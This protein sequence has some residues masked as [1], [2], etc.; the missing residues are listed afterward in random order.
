KQD[1]LKPQG[2]PEHPCVYVTP[3]DVERVRRNARDTAWG[4]TAAAALL[5]SCEPW[6]QHDDAYWRAFL[7]GPGACYAYGFVACPTCGS[8]WGTWGGARCDWDTPGKVTCANGHQ[9]PDAAHPDS[10]GGWHNPDGRIH[11]FV[12]SWNAWVTE[13]WTSAIPTLADAYALTADEKY[14]DRAALFLDL[15]ASIYPETQAGSWDYPSSPPSGRFARPW[16]QV[17][18]TLV[19]YVHAQDL[20]Y[21]SSAL[22]RPSLRPAIAAAFPPQPWPQQA[23]V[24][25]T[26]RR[27]TSHPGMTRRENIDLNL[28]EDGAYY[29][30]GHCFGGMLHNGHADYMRGSLA[31]GALLGI[32]EYIRIATD[33]PYSFWAMVANNCDRDGRY[34]ETSLGYAIHARNL[35]LTFVEPLRNWRNV[36]HPQGYDL[37]ADARFRSFYRLPATVLDCAG[38]EPNF[39]DSSPDHACYTSSARPYRREDHEFAEWLYAGT[40][41]AVKD[42][43]ASVL[44]WMAQGD[45]GSL[46]QSLPAEWMLFH[47]E[48]VPPGPAGLPADLQRQ[49]DGSWFLGQKGIALLRDGELPDQQ[50]AFLR[51]GPSLN[52]GHQDDLGLDYYAKGWQLTYDIGYGLGSTH[53]QVGWAHQTASHTLVT[54]NEAS[55]RG[56]SG[57]SLHRFARL[58]GVQIA[59]ADSPLSYAEQKVTEYR[60]TIALLGHGADQVLVDLFRVAGGHQHDYLVGGQSQEVEVAGVT[61][62]AEQP[63]SLAGPDPAW[64]ERLGLDGDVVGFP[65]KPYWNPPP[66][67]GYGFFYAPRRAPAAQ[68]WTVDWHLG[69]APD[70]HF[71]VHLLPEPGTE[72]IGAK[73]PGLYPRDRKAV[74]AIAR[75]TGAEG[76]RSGFAAVMEPYARPLLIGRL[77]ALQLRSHVAEADRV[78]RYGADYGGYLY[79]GGQQAGDSLTFR[80]DAPAAGEYELSL[81][82]LRYHGYGAVRASLDGQ[83]AGDLMN[84][85]GET[86]PLQHFDLGRHTLAAGEHRLKLEAAPGQPAFAFGVQAVQL[87]PVAAG[88][89]SL[90]VEPA[91]VVSL[92]D[93]L[94]VTGPD[95]AEPIAVHLRRAG[96]DEYLLSAVGDGECTATGAHGKLSWRGGVA[97]AAFAGNQLVALAT[98]GAAVSGAGF[99]LTPAATSLTGS[100]T[101]VDYEH[102][103]VDTA[104]KLPAAGLEGEAVIY[105]RPEWSRTSA[106]RIERIEPL[107]NG[108]RI[109][110]GSQSLLLGQGRVMDIRDDNTVLSDIP[111]EFTR[112]VVGGTQTRFF[113]GK[114]LV[115]GGGASTRIRR[116]TFAQPMPITVEDASVLKPGDTIRYY[117]LGV[118]DGFT[119]PTAALVRLE[120]GKWRLESTVAA[121]LRLPGAKGGEAAATGIGRSANVP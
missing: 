3:A 36:A 65:N 42:E 50:A 8:S 43:Y 111:H 96:L 40:S 28:I 104:A 88:A 81:D 13:Q 89:P 74:Y 46:R 84:V 90:A 73:A 2:R 110:L 92:A 115:T 66:G 26:D 21:G 118:G 16:Y 47:A 99:A 87:R 93:R 59:E 102:N 83:P 68:P 86:A 106:Y 62:G 105:S 100:I 4:K 9:L 77:D 120:D 17:A 85:R 14:A 20:I 34:Y 6:L 22:D 53:T 103:T 71:R 18:R 112:S 95:A 37:L 1:E 27:G 82:M 70:S 32:P 97:Y 108:S 107:A 119:I 23:E 41:G 19:R 58:P 60:R 64:G 52:H 38:H 61:L 94:P 75:R 31:A 49:V 24:R 80:L 15:L 72:A 121:T 116:M 51:F 101:A 29:C 117:D 67:N 11:Y 57:G 69:G 78:Y 76:L 35:Y 33:G 12:G 10:G 7:P 114:L 54:V 55:Q 79:F 45:L 39:G 56:G 44:R 98:C 91:P 63:G 48:P 109:H 113:D 25:T 30:Y 5:A